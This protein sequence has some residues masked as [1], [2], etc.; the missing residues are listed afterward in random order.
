M[1]GSLRV[2]LPFL[3]VLA[4]AACAPM[5]PEAPTRP[6]A[7]AVPETPPA[8]TVP[9]PP[10]TAP[11]G[12][13][14]LSADQQF[15]DQAAGMNASQIG[16]GRLADGKGA[17][18]AVRRFAQGMVTDHTEEDRRLGLLA[19]RLHMAVAPPGDEPPPEL[20]IARGPDFDKKY[21]ALVIAGHQGMIASFEGEANSG[22]DTRLKHYAMSVLP[23]LRNDLHEAQT[24]AQR[25]GG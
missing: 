2:V 9:A 3:I 5:P 11:P 25:V 20:V 21:L 7:S 19:K 16:M 1:V 12:A 4:L 15:I 14:A 17:E 6:I 23:I 24:L 10:P 13:P 8:E 22:Q 18:K